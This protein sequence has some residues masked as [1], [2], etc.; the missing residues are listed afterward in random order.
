MPNLLTQL[1]NGLLLA[2]FAVC[3]VACGD[4]EGTRRPAPLDPPTFEIGE[5]LPA[6]GP[7]WPRSACEGDCSSHCVELG[8]DPEQTTYVRVELRNWT[9]KPYLACHG[10]PQCGFV[11]LTV[12]DPDG[13]PPLQVS[14][15]ATSI[16][17]ELA[18]LTSPEG[19]L[20]FRVELRD[21]EGKPAEN[22]PF[23][24][25]VTV[26]VSARCGGTFPS[27]ASAPDAT[28]DAPSD[29]GPPDSATRDAAAPDA[30]DAAPAV[31][32]PA[33]T[34]APSDAMDAPIVDAPGD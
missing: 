4:D 29:A 32:A 19:L 6:G 2:T 9:L 16:P 24:D 33:D 15:A 31:D 28:A 18:R 13:D 14:A 10:A 5:L 7:A 3:T 22:G 34:G 8:R 20:T 12:T 25:E 30:T 11:L 17:A 26:Q 1:E 21:E 23:V 27:D